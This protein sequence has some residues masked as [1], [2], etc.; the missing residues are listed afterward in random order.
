MLKARRYMQNILFFRHRSLLR[1]CAHPIF[2]QICGKKISKIHI[3]FLFYCTSPIGIC[4]FQLQIQLFKAHFLKICFYTKLYIFIY[5]LPQVHNAIMQKCFWKNSC[6]LFSSMSPLLILWFPPP[7]KNLSSS[8]CL[9]TV[10]PLAW[11]T[12]VQ[13]P[14]HQ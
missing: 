7:L 13:L 8:L 5:L 2:F 14:S 10:N 4:R 12:I 3:K 6:I 1:F 11:M 9:R